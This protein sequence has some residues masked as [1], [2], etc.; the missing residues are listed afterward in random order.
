MPVLVAVVALAVGGGLLARELYQDPPA[1]G[2]QRPTPPV[3]TSMPPK[4]QPG[5]PRVRLAPD[6]AE[7]PASGPIRAALQRYF[8]GI[9]Q[10]DYE[11]WAAAVVPERAM[12]KP[13]E[14]WLADYRTTRSGSI[15]LHRIQTLPDAPLTVL[16]SFTSTQDP[17]YAP[18][19]LRRRC[20][21]WRLVWPMT[22]EYGDWMLDTV[23]PGTTSEMEP[24]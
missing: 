10:R 6:A 17:E 8:D 2:D 4:Q 15:V 11:L 21:H 7:H 14:V 13:P 3:T 23:P 19:D 24:C 20:I 1:V 12:N 22:D 18:E 16:I 9:N 5:S